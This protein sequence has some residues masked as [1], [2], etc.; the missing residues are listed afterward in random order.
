MASNYADVLESYIIYD[1][2][3]EGFGEAIKKA[4]KFVGKVL[5]S[6]IQAIKRVLQGMVNKIRQLASRKNGGKKESK[7]DM[8]ERLSQENDEK[9][10][11]I[12]MLERALKNQKADSEMWEE[13]YKERS[14][15]AAKD[16]ERN[17][18]ELRQRNEEL[19][20]ANKEN[21]S[22]KKDNSKLSE[23]KEKATKMIADLKKEIAA[24]K[25]KIESI[26][27]NA[28]T[29]SNYDEFKKASL[30]FISHVTQQIN[31][32]YTVLPKLVAEAKKF[33]GANR[34]ALHES[35]DGSYEDTFIDKRNLDLPTMHSGN[36]SYLYK[37]LKFSYLPKVKEDKGF[38]KWDGEVGRGFEIL[39]KQAN[40][41]IEYLEKMVKDMN[42]GGGE[43]NPAYKNII[44]NITEDDGF[45]DMLRTSINL[46]NEILN[47]YVAHGERIIHTIYD[48]I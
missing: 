23:K 41:T 35:K 22:L 30:K 28:N 45:I 3:E 26:K 25:E 40:Q 7:N 36:W 46:S 43:N 12:Q 11:K 14:D 42:N 32:A 24:N 38:V 34:K 13:A 33:D 31:K 6:I 1:I 20:S 39:I 10:R 16:G 37:T 9:T 19:Y 17:L 2:A 29:E 48:A 44:Q 8:I 27:K 21:D 5:L 4:G 47:C 18:K 15:R